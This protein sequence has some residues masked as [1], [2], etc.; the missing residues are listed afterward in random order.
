[1]RRNTAQKIKDL[2]T[3]PLRAFTLFHELGHIFR[4]LVNNNTA[5]FLDVDTDNIFNDENKEEREADDFAKNSLISP[6]NWNEY[7]RTATK[8]QE[9]SI[10]NLARKVRIHPAIVKGRLCHELNNYRLKTRI[11]HNIY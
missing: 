5:E 8:S 4:H 10:L 9:K 6:G 7:F 11:D 3:F 1:M 2:V